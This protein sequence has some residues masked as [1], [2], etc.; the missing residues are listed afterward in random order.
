[1]PLKRQAFLQSIS[2]LINDKVGDKRV[3]GRKIKQSILNLPII[4]Y[5]LYSEIQIL[6]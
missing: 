1:M 5:K 3:L 2:N 6:L 4:L